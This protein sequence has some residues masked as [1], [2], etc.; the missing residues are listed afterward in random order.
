[1]AD[2]SVLESDSDNEDFL[3]FNSTASPSNFA[4]HADD[5]FSNVDVSSVDSDDLTSSE[6]DS[7]SDVGEG[8]GGPAVWSEKLHASNNNNTF[9][10]PRPGAT[11]IL[12]GESNEL[13]FFKLFFRNELIEVSK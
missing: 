6:D 10:G 8:G 4:H 1:M 11:A 13:D 9:V 3:G 12:S 5:N 2:H 7:D